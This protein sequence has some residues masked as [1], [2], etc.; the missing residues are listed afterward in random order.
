[1]D[2]EAAMVDLL[3][4][5]ARVREAL[6]SIPRSAF[7]RPGQRPYALEDRPLDIGE[8]QTTSQPSLIAWTLEQLRLRP[9]SRVLEVGTGCGY[10]TALLS[11]LCAQVYSIDIIEPLVRGAKPVLERL[12][13]ANVH[14]RV[15][16]G[17]LGWPEAA[18]FDAIVVA[19][20]ASVMPAPL[21]EQLAPGGRMIIPVGEPDDMTLR[22]VKRSASGEVTEE[23]LIAV[24]FVPL[25]GPHAE[26]DQKAKS[27][28]SFTPG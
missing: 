3:I 5:D 8:G 23:K 22:L 2:W 13:C 11:R 19:A 25:T 16:D 17:Y 6:E 10:Q 7:L 12:G 24:R 27:R 1:M 14:L 9:G 21:V 15:A 28:P 20:G 26:L 4:T 18:P